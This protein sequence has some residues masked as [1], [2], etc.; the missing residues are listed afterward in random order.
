MVRG[1]AFAII[2]LASILAVSIILLFW[3]GAPG[4]SEKTGEPTTLLCPGCNVVFIVIE[5]TRADHLGCYGYPRNTT[6]RIDSLAHDGILFE[7][8]FTARGATWPSISSIL[9]SKHP[10]STGIRENGEVTNRSFDTLATAMGGAGYRTAA[11]MSSTFCDSGVWGFQTKYC[12]PNS[13]G[14]ESDLNLTAEAFDWLSGNRDGRFLLFVHY[15]APHNPYYPQGE[16]DIFTD[17]NYSGPYNGSTMDLD[18]IKRRKIALSAAELDYLVSRYDGELYFADS[19]IGRLYDRFG[20]LGLLN[21][22]VFILT[23]DHGEELYQR[24]FYFYHDC[25][26]YDSVLHIPFIVSV[27]SDRWNGAR[28]SDIVESVDFAPTVLDAVG[29][30]APAGFEGRSAVPLI[31]GKSAGEPFAFAI[32]ERYVRGVKTFDRERCVVNA[33]AKGAPILSITDGRWR[34][35]Y[36]PYNVTPRCRCRPEGAEYFISEEELYDMST[37]P[38]EKSDVS[39]QNRDVTERLRVELLRRYRDSVEDATTA[40]DNGTV[41]RLKSLGYVT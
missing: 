10:A 7:N 20:E 29:V 24:N 18:H 22:T 16:Y 28:I 27:P 6:P 11:F 1:K 34:Y 38:L 13:D 25:S 35:I 19:L 15:L 40:A 31:V 12:S 14:G 2:L 8:A 23:S 17:K 9:T 3:G 41:E 5:T 21:R 33:T 26:V 39:A 30:A 37:D 32:S 4:E 36:N